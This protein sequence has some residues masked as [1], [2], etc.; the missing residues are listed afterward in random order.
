MRETI[1]VL[2]KGEVLADE[3]GSKISDQRQSALELAVGLS[4]ILASDLSIILM[5][6]N[7]PQVGFVLF[8][9]ELASHVLHTIPL[10]VCGADTQGA[11][12]YMLSQ[13][14]IN[15]LHKAQIS[16]S[17]VSV[18]TQTR[19]DLSNVQSEKPTR[20]IGPWFDRDKAEQ[21]RRSRGWTMQEDTG[22]GYRRAVPCLPA[23][24]ILEIESIRQLV[25]SGAIVIAGGGG[26]IPVTLTPEGELR[27][28][29]AVLDTDQVSCLMARQLD[30]SILLTIVDSDSKFILSG[31]STERATYLSRDDLDAILRQGSV[32]SNSIH[33]Q[34][35]SA[36]EFLHGG[37]EEVIITTLR[38]L[39]QTLAKQCGLR[40]VSVDPFS[41]KI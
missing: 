7:K 3:R 26:G 5:H 30:A 15:V 34:L 1:V 11:T 33:R 16:R 20:M 6:G 35:V 9:S 41:A 24:E 8:R 14:L 32:R 31:L 28:V 12:G 18:V 38:K 22:H 17:V 25:S 23:E 13:A 27:G 40:I 37:G 2:A 29:E 36:S 4:P 21:Y 39:P 19:V 10:D